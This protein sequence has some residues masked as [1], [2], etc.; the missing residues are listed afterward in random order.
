[1]KDIFSQIGIEVT[2]RN[3]NEIDRKI[4]EL[5]GA[6]YKD[7]SSTWKAIKDRLVE[8]EEQFISDLK[9]ALLEVGKCPKCDVLLTIDDIRQIALK[10][11]HTENYAYV[12]KKCSYII[13]FGVKA[14]TYG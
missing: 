11:S 4:H 7:C 1:M 5:V 9:S 14:L 3:R 8:N 6:K 2:P 10:I 13:G 12:C